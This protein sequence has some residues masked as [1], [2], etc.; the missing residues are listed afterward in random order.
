MLLPLLYTCTMTPIIVCFIED[1]IEPWVTLDWVVTVL[2]GCDIVVTFFT[3]FHNK[4][5]ELVTNRCLIARR[6][7]RFW[8]WIDVIATLPI[9]GMAQVIFLMLIV[10]H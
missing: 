10:S 6:Y 4:H 3:A 1:D 7:L 5:K 9:G 8:F 2:F